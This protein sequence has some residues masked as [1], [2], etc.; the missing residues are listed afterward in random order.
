MQHRIEHQSMGAGD[1]RIKRIEITMC[2]YMTDG[3][4]K[5]DTFDG[6]AVIFFISQ[7]KKVEGQDHTLTVTAGSAHKVMTICEQL[8]DMLTKLL[9]VLEG[10]LN[11]AVARFRKKHDMKSMPVGTLCP[12]GCGQVK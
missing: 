1:N 8:P 3:S 6:D 12:C 4:V 10:M 11:E 7:T 9:E 5:L 2:Q